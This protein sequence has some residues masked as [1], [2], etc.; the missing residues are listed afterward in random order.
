MAGKITKEMT[1]GEA[2]TMLPEAGGVMMKYG[3]HC[4]GCH[5]AA[6]ETI[7]QGCL[8]HGLSEEDI[9]KMLKE[10]NELAGKKKK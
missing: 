5:V 10:L 8:A 6:Y 1:F 4:I 2:I 7:E 3:L 9:T